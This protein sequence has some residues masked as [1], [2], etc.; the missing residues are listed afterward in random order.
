MKFEWFVA[1]RYLTAKRKQAFISVIT[2]ISVLGI[3]I[4]VMALI[5]AIALITGFQKDVQAKILGSTSHI[6]VSDLS[7]KGI[8]D[9]EV[10]L[11][12]VKE[13]DGITEVTPVAYITVFITGPYKNSG[14]VLRGLDFEREETAS[15][16]KDN[17]ERGD[18]PG[19]G[20]EG[21]NILLGW[22][23]AFDLGAGVGDMVTVL[24]V[25]NRLTPTGLFPRIKKLRVTGIFR[26]GLYEYD[27]ST[28]LVDLKTAQNIIG[29]NNKVN[30]IQI[31]IDNIFKAPAFKEEIRDIIPPETYVTTWMEMNESLFSAL[32]LEKKLMFFTIALII[33]VAALNII[34]T[35]ILMVMEKTKDIG[36]LMAMGA[37]SQ[38]IRKI[39]FLQGATIGI[40]GTFIG[41][42]LGL[43]W[44]W[45]AN[46]FEL[47][48]VPIDIYQI[49]FVPFK[50]GILDLLVI[51]F[52][53]IFISFVSTLFP[54][55]RAAKIDPVGALKYE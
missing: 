1:K 10:F 17:L 32:K 30:L 48:K 34:A 51:I 28:A 55:Y 47:I 21:E 27:A 7:G 49:P 23:L 19:S 13:M 16:W 2:L 41:T 22:D 33:L 3:T 39:F 35:L 53:A 44:C 26:T 43:A 42:V 11:E 29:I 50:I 31:K 25:S 52:S 45:L 14:I 38:S 9:Y 12:R 5:I 15:F 4:G 24:S 54:S 8:S 18:L 40:L 6:M 37:T 46:T 36:I 20:A